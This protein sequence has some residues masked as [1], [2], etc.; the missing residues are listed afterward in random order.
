MRLGVLPLGRSTF[1]VE[2]A[3]R[4]LVAALR[5]L[6][7]T[8]HEVFG[9]R[10]L[11]LDEDA[12]LRAIGDLAA[13]PVDQVLILQLTFTDARMTVAA[14]EAF[15]Q[16]LSIWAMPEPR[17]GGRLRLNALCGLNLASHAL[18]LK[19]RT[20]SWLYAD[21]GSGVA[22][23]IADLLAGKCKTADLEA[24]AVP[25]ATVGG[26]R[27]A[28]AIRGRRI[29]RI[30]EHPAGFDTCAY[31]ASAVHAL[32]GVQVDELELDDLFALARA[33]PD[34]ATCG[35]RAQARDRLAGLDALD[36]GEL[37]RSFRLKLA[38]DQFA[39]GTRLRCLC[40]PVLARDLY[41]V[42]GRRLRPGRH[43]RRGRGA[44]CLRG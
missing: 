15:E 16:P 39:K 25:S 5:G 6:D 41:R 22:G 18:G 27:V 12:T 19:N 38:M 9:S 42:R 2:Y 1:D 43:A 35:L 8:G 44:L 14:A 36:A 32:A 24:P 7:A 29:A 3:G 4:K 40:D 37:D 20:F 28:E 17:L 11:L 34:R 10:M 23:R 21:P 31:E 26:A 13:S 33:L 30:G